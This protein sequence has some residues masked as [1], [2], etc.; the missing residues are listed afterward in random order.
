MGKERKIK[1]HERLEKMMSDEMI[2]TEKSVKEK[3]KD[4]EFLKTENERVKKGLR[5]LTI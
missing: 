4:V 2:E 5:R 3:M 1:G